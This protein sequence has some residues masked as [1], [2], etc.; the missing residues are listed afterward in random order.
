MD[1]VNKEVSKFLDEQNLPLRDEIENLR[2][3][4]LNATGGLTENI[5]WNGPNYCF[6]EMDRITMRIQPPK[7]I[8]LIFHRGAKKMEQPKARIIA[9]DSKLLSWKENDR[10]VITFK[11]LTA[12]ENA[13]ADLKAII[14]EWIEKTA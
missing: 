14:N 8:Q 7:Q 6:N 5:K 10:A 11:D 3:I 1:Y 9:S 13:K 12:I 2:S 4:V